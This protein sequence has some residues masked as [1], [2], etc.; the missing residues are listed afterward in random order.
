[1]KVKFRKSDGL[2]DTSLN[3]CHVTATWLR[4]PEHRGVL[5]VARNLYLHP[6]VSSS[7]FY[8][9]IAQLGY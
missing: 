2:L 6:M 9:R 8:A 1:M 4:D 3:L 7:L 5:G